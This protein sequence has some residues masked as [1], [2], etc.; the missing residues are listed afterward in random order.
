MVYE[1]RT[2]V[3]EE[4]FDQLINYF[5]GNSTKKAIENQV[6][7]NYHT[8]GDFRLIRSKEYVQLDFKSNTSNNVVYVDKKYEKDLINIF[9]NIGT[10]IDFKRFRNRYKYIYENFYITI[11][12]NIKTGNILR[13]KFNYNNEEEKSKLLDQINNLFTELQIEQT[14]LENFQ[15][16]YGKYRTS[17][18]DLVGDINEDEFIK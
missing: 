16:L 14:P 8:E 1:L 3:K 2:V 12:K 11:D 18:A 4:K 10:A 5:D 15:E 17:W 7:Y 13:I 9:K 6:I